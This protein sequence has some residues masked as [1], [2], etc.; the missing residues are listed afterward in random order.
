ASASSGAGASRVLD[1]D[2]DGYWSPARG[3][4]GYLEL[5]FPSPVTFGIVELREAIAHGQHVERYEVHARTPEGWRV[6]ADGSTI[7]NRS[8]DRTDG[9]VTASR[10]RVSIEA[11]HEVPRISRVGL[12]GGV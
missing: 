11:A 4:T 2:I 5:E 7:G 1:A 8:L 12:Y 3:T 6:V 9:P 10:L